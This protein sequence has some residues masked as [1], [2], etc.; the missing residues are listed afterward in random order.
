MSEVLVIGHRN[1]DTDSI[2]SAIAYAEFKRKTGMANAIAARCGDTNDRID[3][4]LNS[5]GFGPPRFVS[6]VSPKVRDVMAENVVSIPP[7]ATAAEAIGIMDERNIRVLPVLNEDLTCRGL[8]SR[9]KMSKVFFPAPN[10][11]FDSRRVNAS[12]RNLASTLG[13][14]MIFA[15]EPNR[16]EDLI[17]MVGA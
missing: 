3:F 15:L 14:Q 2:C 8:L 10:R 12:L 13:A 17:L 9:F 16:V 5:F 4:V 1:P 6:D 11:L 7:H